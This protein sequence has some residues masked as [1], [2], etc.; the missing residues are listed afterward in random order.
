MKTKH[1]IILSCVLVVGLIFSGLSL[2]DDPAKGAH[3]G[4]GFKRHRS[5]GGLMLLAKY[6]QK[7]LMVQTLSE[8]TGQSAETIETQ[9]KGRRMRAAVMEDLDIDRQAFRTTLQAKVN[10]LV[11]SA[12]ASG[13]ITAEQ[14]KEILAKMET[15]S[16]RR[17]I[18]SRLVEKGVAD[19]T[20]TQ[21]QAQML[22]RKSR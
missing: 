15:H 16:Q 20:I 13:S 4:F 9:L 10:R 18:M 17:E 5:G 12:A 7:N 21:E 1:T 8:M 2:A 3:Q 22:M 19:G 11:K 6:Q 14:E